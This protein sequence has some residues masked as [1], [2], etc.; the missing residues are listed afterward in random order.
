MDWCP[1]SAFHYSVQCFKIK[2]IS[3]F[4]CIPISNN[5]K[6]RGLLYTIMESETLNKEF[7]IF[8]N[9]VCHVYIL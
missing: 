9:E 7:I 1:L 5:F 6:R 8:I 3:S 4:C 2:S